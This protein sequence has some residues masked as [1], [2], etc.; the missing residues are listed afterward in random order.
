MNKTQKQII[1]DLRIY[2]DVFEENAREDRKNYYL[3][4][5]EFYKEIRFNDFL[6]NRSKLHVIEDILGLSE[7]KIEI[8][9]V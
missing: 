8:V 9:I 4:D 2:R 5:R 3:E 6:E 7:T 1:N